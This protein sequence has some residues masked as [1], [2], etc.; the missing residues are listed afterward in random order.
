MRSLLLPAGLMLIVISGCAN[1]SLPE[2]GERVKN[3]AAALPPSSSNV[4]DWPVDEREI[5]PSEF[6][7]EYLKPATMEEYNKAD[8]IFLGCDRI[9]FYMAIFPLLDVGPDPSVLLLKAK[10]TGLPDGFPTEELSKERKRLWDILMQQPLPQ[11]PGRDL[12]NRQ[13]DKI[14]AERGIEREEG[15]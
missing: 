5:G 9:Y 13:L 4:A 1:Q 7:E 3:D 14:I 12:K 15:K 11:K 8:R 6:S 2:T 10:K